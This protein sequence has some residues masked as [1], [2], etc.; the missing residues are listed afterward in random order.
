MFVFRTIS[1]TNSFVIRIIAFIS[2]MLLDYKFS[3]DYVQDYDCDYNYV[4]VNV[5]VYKKLFLI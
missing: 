5:N 4:N 2:M 3:D 1:N